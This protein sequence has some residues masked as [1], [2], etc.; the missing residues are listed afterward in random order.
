M[1]RPTPYT[2]E[3]AGLDITNAETFVESQSLLC[4]A[5]DALAQR[6]GMWNTIA[7]ELTITEDIPHDAKLLR[8]T[9][10]ADAWTGHAWRRGMT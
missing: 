9:F 5:R 8:V 2:D 1:T 4:R 7:G 10:N 6:S 3:V